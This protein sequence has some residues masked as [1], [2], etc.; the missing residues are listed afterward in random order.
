MAKNESTDAIVANEN[1][2]AEIQRLKLDVQS[3]DAQLARAG[4]YDGIEDDVAW[5]V[6]AGLTVEEATRVARRNRLTIEAM[7]I[8]DQTQ[9]EMALLAASA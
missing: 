1:K 6:R 3:K 9:R 8:K 2:D 5:R 4:V 7:K